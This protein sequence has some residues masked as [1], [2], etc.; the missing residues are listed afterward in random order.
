MRPLLDLPEMCFSRK[1][2]LIK[3]FMSQPLLRW[4]GW[5]CFNRQLLMTKIGDD[6][7]LCSLFEEAWDAK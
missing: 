2:C 7:R 5:P 4:F 3:Q 6:R 1:S